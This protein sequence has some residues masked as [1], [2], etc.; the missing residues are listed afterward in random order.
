MGVGVDDLL[1]DRGDR[2]S[3]SSTAS[4]PALGSRDRHVS[5]RRARATTS[6]ARWC[7]A[8]T[9]RSVTGSTPWAVFGVV[10]RLDPQKGFDLVAG[11]AERLVA[12][13]GRL[14]VLGTGDHGLVS[15]LKALAKRLPDRI[16]ASIAST[17][18]R[19]GGSTPGRMYS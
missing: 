2:Y 1:R 17:A 5:R 18:T 10:G 15:G 3:G 11:A 13:G 8:P 6:P 4:T 9:W 12:A 7:A 19:R 14:I 16:V